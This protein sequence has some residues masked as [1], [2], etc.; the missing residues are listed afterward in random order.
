MCRTSRRDWPGYMPY[1][2]GQ[3]RR[4]RYFVNW[5]ARSALTLR[6]IP[7][8]SFTRLLTNLIGCLNVSIAHMSRMKK[9][10]LFCRLIPD[11]ITFVPTHGSPF[12]CGGSGWNESLYFDLFGLD[13]NQAYHFVTMTSAPELVERI[14]C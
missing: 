3:M 7:S 13:P 8:H 4:G 11:W 2:V 10:F 12:F 6:V 9:T 1:L 14:R 5:K